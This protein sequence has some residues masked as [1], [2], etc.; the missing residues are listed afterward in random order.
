ML[1]RDGDLF[2][3]VVN[4]ASRLGEIAKPGTV[5]VSEPLSVAIELDSRFDLRTM[6]PRKLRGIGE[7]KLSALRDGPAW[8]EHTDE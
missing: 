3:P 2:G 1:T 7:V 5:L 6:K 8:A 4:L